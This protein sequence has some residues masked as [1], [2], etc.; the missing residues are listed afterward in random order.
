MCSYKAV[1]V[2]FEVWGLQTNVESY[3]H[4]VSSSMFMFVCGFLLRFTQT[5]LCKCKV[6]N[7]KLALLP[8]KAGH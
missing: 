8:F 4:S 1:R 7:F 2:K 6:G 3:V 5:I